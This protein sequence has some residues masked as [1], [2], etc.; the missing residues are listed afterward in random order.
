MASPRDVF[1]QAVSRFSVAPDVKPMMVATVRFSGKGLHVGRAVRQAVD[2]LTA[3]ATTPLSFV[4][5][6]PV[7]GRARAFKTPKP[8]KG[9][10]A[11]ES[12]SR[13]GDGWDEQVLLLVK[14]GDPA[15]GL[16][17]APD[18]FA[19]FV[20]LDEETWEGGYLTL[21]FP[22]G[23]EARW[24]APLEAALA[25]V[26]AD[27][28]TLS[29]ALWG[30]PQSPFFYDSEVLNEPPA[31]V[32]EF[33]TTFPQ[34]M[35]PSLEGAQHTVATSKVEPNIRSGFLAPAWT[36]WVSAPLGAKAR[37]FVGERTVLP[38]GYTRLRIGPSP[39]SMGASGYARWLE[40]WRSMKALH[41]HL[42]LDEHDYYLERFSGPSA[43]VLRRTWLAE[44]EAEAARKRLLTALD[45]LGEG[46]SAVA[47]AE[48]LKGQVEPEQLALRVV[49]ALSALLTSKQ[50]SRAKAE[51][52]LDY[53]DREC[54][55]SRHPHLWQAAA[56]LAMQCDDR[57]R[58][59]RWLEQLL[60]E[61]WWPYGMGGEY[62][63]LAP[64][65][66]R[67]LARD[68]EFKALVAAAR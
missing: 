14:D 1:L 18:Q 29:P 5:R 7:R 28:A 9:L 46:A 38:S 36:M 64:K 15:E 65:A 27:V 68:A 55:T 61:G 54:A 66:L 60:R 48:Q 37:R 11:L 35:L 57:A 20:G 2:A 53:V 26:R 59:L 63:L 30:L 56:N 4:A 31:R 43:A 52:W 22:F 10:E 62:G 42:D 50:V 25:L 58:A 23:E 67:P 17:R 45:S 3:C 33:H 13:I 32:V 16:T 21:G 24:L 8:W 39:Y 6:L 44:L 49:P 51:A 34:V 47:R 41:L 19:L 12:I 40:A